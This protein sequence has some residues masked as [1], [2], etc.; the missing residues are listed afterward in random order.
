MTSRNLNVINTTLSSAFDA[1]AITGNCGDGGNSGITTTTSATQTWSGTSGGNWSANAWT[2]R[3]PL[4]Q[5]DVVISSSF[6]A[7][8]TITGDMPRLGRSINW[9][10]S[11]GSPTWALNSTSNTVYGSMTLISGMTL[12]STSSLTFAGAQTSN[13]ITSAGKSYGGT[14]AFS[15]TN[16][17]VWTLQDNF[18]TTSTLTLTQGSF[19]A[20]GNN[21]T[22]TTFCAQIIT[23]VTSGD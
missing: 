3:V 15:G 11:T 1:H 10:G 16:A 17:A 7:S 12:T 2:S 6:T 13:T 18:A 21:V 19:S 4:P 9:T 5:D 14:V 20:N 22:C 8:Q 23:V